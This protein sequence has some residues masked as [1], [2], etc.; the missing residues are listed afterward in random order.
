[1]R[2]RLLMLSIVMLSVYMPAQQNE[3]PNAGF[4]NWISDVQPEVWSTG[5]TIGGV[6]ANAITRTNTAF[7]GQY[8]V[9]GEIM[10]HPLAPGNPWLPSLWLGA[11]ANPPAPISKNYTHVKGKY[12]IQNVNQFLTTLQVQVNFLDANMLLTAIGHGFYTNNSGSFT[13]FE[14]LMDYEEGGNNNNDAAFMQIII[15]LA[16][17]G[18]DPD[19][20]IGSYFIVDD[21]ELVENPTGLAPGDPNVPAAFELHQNY[22]NPFNPSTTFEFS[23]PVAGTAKLTIYN[24]LG[25]TVATLVDQPLAAGS[26]RY[27]W[28]AANLPSGVYIYR[29]QAGAF[30]QSKKLMLTH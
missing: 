6:T 13:E 19:Y 27:E 17:D 15:D 21:L 25:E 1:M 12:L 26:Y 23:L 30:S 28:D 11:I 29:L 3:I 16:P 24:M 10:E 4:E 5:N 2:F 22:P 9:R 18:S 8:A 20:G 14:I 7:S